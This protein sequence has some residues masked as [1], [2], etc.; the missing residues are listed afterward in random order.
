MLIISWQGDNDEG[1]GAGDSEHKVPN[2][3]ANREAKAMQFGISQGSFVDS[4]SNTIYW[5]WGDYDFEHRAGS[6]LLWGFHGLVMP[7]HC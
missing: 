2:G 3:I 1:F 7:A 5:E 4:F 6:I